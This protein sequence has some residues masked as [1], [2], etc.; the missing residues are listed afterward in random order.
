LIEKG[1]V[2]ISN[3]DE[4]DFSCDFSV[5]DFEG[6]SRT[7]TVFAREIGLVRLSARFERLE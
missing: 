3:F 5:L 4:A 2:F 6:T 7:Y 1:I